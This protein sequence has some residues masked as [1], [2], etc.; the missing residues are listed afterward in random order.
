M[1]NS[2]VLELIL[3]K[4]QGMEEKIHG[5]ESKIYGMEKKIETVGTDFDD[6]KNGQEEIIINLKKLETKI[7]NEL[8]EKIRGLYDSREV[9]RDKLSSIN[10][11]VDNLSDRIDKHE[12]IIKLA[13]DSNISS[14]KENIL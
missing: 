6:L 3:A 7:E 10:I 14:T 5:M 11:K 4:L 9:I 13:E 12:L 2:Q 1:D 8:T